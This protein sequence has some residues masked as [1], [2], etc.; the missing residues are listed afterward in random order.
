MLEISKMIKSLTDTES[1]LK[2]IIQALQI[3][4]RGIQINYKVKIVAN[5]IIEFYLIYDC[6]NETDKFIIG[7]IDLISETFKFCEE[8]EDSG[9]ITKVFFKFLF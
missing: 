1:E 9:I 3:C 2:R 5:N 4:D 7:L 6:H 8:T